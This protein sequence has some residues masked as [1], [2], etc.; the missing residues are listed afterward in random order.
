MYG[1]RAAK[2]AA[3]ELREGNGLGDYVKYW[4][5]SYEYH[6][7]EKRE[8]AF[9]TALGITNLMDEEIDYLFAVMEPYKIKSYYDEFDAPKKIIAAI[10]KQLPKIRKERPELAER[11]EAVFQSTVEEIFEKMGMKKT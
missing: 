2:A 11:V 1:F 9:R 3:K 4:Q 10:T 6:I 7:P 8:Q 5:D